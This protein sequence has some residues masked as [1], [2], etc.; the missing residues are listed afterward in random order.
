MKKNFLQIQNKISE[1][2]NEAAIGHLARTILIGP[3]SDLNPRGASLDSILF[4]FLAN[5][6]KFKKLPSLTEIPDL[7]K[8]IKNDF[9]DFDI[10]GDYPIVVNLIR[11][12][13]CR[14]RSI[15]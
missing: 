14:Y 12:C 8:G 5:T 1:D 9:G 13:N 6:Y 3:M 15:Y 10:G 2:S 4:P 7:S 11:W